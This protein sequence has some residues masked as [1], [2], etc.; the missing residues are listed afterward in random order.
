MDEGPI[1]RL[2]SAAM[3]LAFFPCSR[4]TTTS[5]GG[6]EDATNLPGASARSLLAGWARKVPEGG[7]KDASNEEK[8]MAHWGKAAGRRAPWAAEVGA[9]EWGATRT[10]GVG[11]RTKGGKRAHMGRAGYPKGLKLQPSVLTQQLRPSCIT[12]ER[13]P[14]LIKKIKE[15]EKRNCY[16]RHYPVRPRARPDPYEKKKY[17]MHPIYTGHCYIHAVN[18][19]HVLPPYDPI[20]D[21]S[22]YLS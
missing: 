18:E 12:G 2:T 5:G 4:V 8:A 1:G 20:A 11:E 13:V 17:C 14:S 16:G 7:K 22:S 15:L 3:S 10:I 19:C 9:E 21:R 6:E